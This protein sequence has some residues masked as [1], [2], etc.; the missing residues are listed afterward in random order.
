[1]NRTILRPS[2]ISPRRTSIIGD[3]RAF[4]L[5]GAVAFL[6]MIGGGGYLAAQVTVTPPGD[7]MFSS[8]AEMV[9]RADPAPPLAPTEAVTSPTEHVEWRVYI[10]AG[11]P[12][13]EGDQRG[14]ETA[15]IRIIGGD[16]RA[17]TAH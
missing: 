15:R 8:E 5:S 11:A 7:G 3:V 17:G 14:P 16:G 6:L 13:D 10:Y 12:L 2:P 1:M 4:L 9:T